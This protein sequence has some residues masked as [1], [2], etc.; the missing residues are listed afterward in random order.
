MPDCPNPEAQNFVI[1]NLNKSLKA[2]RGM[3]SLCWASCLCVKEKEN[4]L[5]AHVA[6]NDI[7]IM[8]QME[9]WK[10]KGTQLQT[11]FPWDTS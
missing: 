10:K 8:N 11:N 6:I 1:H 2:L 7:A 5:H 9:V 3:H 4:A